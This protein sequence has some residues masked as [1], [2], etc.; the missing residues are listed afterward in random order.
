M[1]EID[2]ARIGTTTTATPAT[3]R[4]PCDAVGGISVVTGS[5][6]TASGY[7]GSCGFILAVEDSY[8]W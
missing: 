4:K 5:F 6:R 7:P 1:G 2:R 8:D 3:L